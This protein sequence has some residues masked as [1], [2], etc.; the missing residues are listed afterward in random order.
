MRRTVLRRRYA[1]Q[2]AGISLLEVLIAL[3]MF[4]VAVAA[5]ASAVASTSQSSAERRAASLAAAAARDVIERMRATPAHQRFASYNADP[6]DDPG[7]AGTAPGALFAVEGLSPLPGDADG[8]VGVV[9]FAL[10]E[11][12][13][14]E[15]A[16]DARL[17]MPR[18]LNGDTLVD[19]NSRASDYKL[20]PVCIRIEH[21]V[22]G[23]RRVFELHTELA[24]W[25]GA[26]P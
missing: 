17:G 23:D 3:V 5:Y 8:F 6:S 18:D 11:G 25:D 20:L 1:R 26:T 14:R 15:D 24:N 12:Q 22:R 21:E 9:E 16:V 13:L 2:R 19:G 4:T 10:L 7:G